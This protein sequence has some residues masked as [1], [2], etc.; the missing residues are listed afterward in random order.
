MLAAIAAVYLCYFARAILF[1]ITLAL[2]LFF[3]LSPL[4]RYL[5]R[6]RLP[7]SIAAAV[8]VGATSVFLGGVGFVFLT[9]AANWIA[10]APQTF[11][12][13]KEKLQF[14]VE[15]IHKLNRATR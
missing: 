1:P 11:H 3:L 5:M 2:V 7:E 13:A 14:L 8:V 9:P 4:V 6:L 12:K 10:T 15:P